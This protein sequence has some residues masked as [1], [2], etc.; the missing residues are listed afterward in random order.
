MKAIYRK[1]GLTWRYENGSL[2]RVRESGVA[3]EEGDVF[4]CEPAYESAD[5]EDV[6]NVDAASLLDCARE[7]ARIAGD[8]V[9]LERVVL[10]EGF[11]EH[12][13]GERSWSEHSQQLHVALTRGAERVLVDQSSLDCSV[14]SDVVRVLG[15][16]CGDESDAPARLLLAPT[17][18]ASL[19]A[20]ALVQRVEGLELV[21]GAGDFDAYGE[22]VV[23]WPVAR[24]PWP[25]WWRP[26][27]R[28]RPVR[29]PFNVRAVP[30]GTL[31][32]ELPRAV[33]VLGANRPGEL[34][35]LIDDGRRAF[36][37][38]LPRRPV[39]AVGEPQRPVPLG[40]GFIGAEMV[41]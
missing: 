38:V 20:F 25:N 12:E 2:I 17:V 40:A 1:R 33:A 32:R 16:F 37:A 30:H 36:A 3:I 28:T 8:D 24:Q 35:L 15:M 39:L 6:T 34:R 27:Y 11:A 5:P 23:E 18:A 22:A 41:L 9:S 19:L 21:Q 13:F 4:R 7:L 31:E 14:A 26:S 29:M 10:V